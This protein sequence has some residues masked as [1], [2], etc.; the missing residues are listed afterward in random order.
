MAAEAHDDL[1]SPRHKG[2]S[3]APLLA[4]PLTDTDCCRPIWANLWEGAAG[5]TMKSAFRSALDSA[6]ISW[7]QNFQPVESCDN[8]RVPE[9]HRVRMSSL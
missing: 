4:R 8:S 7:P 5:E 2:A 6:P 9:R 3:A 1:E